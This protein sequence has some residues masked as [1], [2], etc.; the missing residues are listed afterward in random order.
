[1]AYPYRK[2]RRTNRSYVRRGRS[3]YS[4]YKLY[5]SRSSGAQA[6][7][8]Y[9][10]NKK[11]KRIQRLTKPEINIAPLVSTT[12]R[13]DQGTAIYTGSNVKLFGLNLTN[14]VSADAEAVAGYARLEGRFARIQ[15]I[16]IKGTF[17]YYNA[18]AGLSVAVQDLQR[19]PAYAR[20]VIYQTKTARDAMPDSADVFSIT[21]SG[22]SNDSTGS[23]GTLLSNYALMRAPLALGLARVA[24]VL[25][26]KLYTISDTKQS[27]MIKTKLK[28]VRNW[29]Q[30]PSDNAPKGQ[31]RMMVLLY[32]TSAS[33]DDADVVAASECRLDLISK[34]VYTDA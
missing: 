30:A 19:Q 1:M 17:S 23:A 4:M 32:N 27:I 3:G 21:T 34:C 10:L 33:N 11:L 15:N 16:T 8:I 5:K 14:M 9:G 31:V 24:K 22:T 2:Y 6:R 18:I 13:S 29:Y 12:M 20:V 7:Q 25:S 26:D 28:Y